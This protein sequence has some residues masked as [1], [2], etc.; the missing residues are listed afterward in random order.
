LISL[1]PELNKAKADGLKAEP[2]KD[3]I[4][5]VQEQLA[6]VPGK[7]VQRRKDQECQQHERE[8]HA[9]DHLRFLG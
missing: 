8:D 7:L 3:A 5:K 2:F 4:V 9:H 1:E 6:I